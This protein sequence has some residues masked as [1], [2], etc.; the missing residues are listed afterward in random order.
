M[1]LIFLTLFNKPSYSHVCVCIVCLH[2]Q[3]TQGT[4]KKFRNKHLYFYTFYV[5]QELWS[6][7]SHIIKSSQKPFEV[8]VT[9]LNLQK[10]K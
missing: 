10:W 4:D 7:F 2:S 6:A 1:A 5:C 9:T 8:G 3:S